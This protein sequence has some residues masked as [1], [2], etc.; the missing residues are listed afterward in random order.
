MKLAAEYLE[1]AVQ[2]ER[3][4]AE[5]EGGSFKDSL[6]KQ[7]AAYR[8]LAGA[9]AEQLGLTAPSARPAGAAMPGDPHECHNR[10]QECQELAARAGTPQQRE[11]LESLGQQWRLLAT[12]LEQLQAMLD[13]YP[14]LDSIDGTDTAATQVPPERQ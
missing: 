12:D 14:A 1:Q 10:A 3:M 13:A 2:F 6:L 5:S 8:K 4:A 7:A 11:L 9:R